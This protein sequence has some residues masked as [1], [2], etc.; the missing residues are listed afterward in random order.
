MRKKYFHKAFAI[1]LFYTICVTACINDPELH[2]SKNKIKI[3][4]PGS[5]IS[6]SKL[7]VKML[8][9][10]SGSPKE[11]DYIMT[12]VLV[13]RNN[14]PIPQKLNATLSVNKRYL[15]YKWKVVP[16]PFLA[17]Y[18]YADTIKIE[19]NTW[20]EIGCRKC[21]YNLYYYWDL[22]KNKEIIKKRSYPEG[23]W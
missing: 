1:C 2:F 19:A 18:Y 13:K 14:R 12:Y 9:S 21:E 3:K 7:M 6:I 11:Y 5:D 4:N 16:D 20:Y 8:D 17:N 15:K 10:S 23:P 22:D